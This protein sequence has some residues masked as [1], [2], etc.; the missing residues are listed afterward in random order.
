MGKKKQQQQQQQQ[1][2]GKAAAD[3]DEDALLAAAIAEAKLLKERQ[4]QDDEEK[5]IAA[6]EAT[7]KKEQALLG[8]SPHAATADA[9]MPPRQLTPNAVVEKLNEIPSFAIM[10]EKEAGAKKTFVPLRFM[11]DNGKQGP[12]TCAFFIDPAEANATLIQAKKAAPDLNL[13]VGVMPLGNAFAL[14]NGWA[15]AQ[16]SCPF[17][18]RGEPEMA[19]QVRPQLKQQLAERGLA[20]WWQFPVI[21]CDELQSPAVLPIFLTR[22][23]LNATWAACEREGPPPSKLQVI[24][25]RLLVKKLLAPFAETGFDANI[26][27]FLGSETAWNV[28]QRSLAT[29]G[30][31]AAAD[32]ASGSG[33]GTS[34]GDAAAARGIDA[35][36]KDEPPP[37]APSPPSGAAVE[38][39]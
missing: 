17:S 9:A 6:M 23:G 39:R 25:M 24:D 13:V 33:S 29:R 30:A 31:P 14:A 11:D 37:L 12:E 7:M 21:L 36:D 28:V 3:Q 19:S 16:G 34:G 20:S 35:D 1:R 27:R 18:V 8:R 26:V 38:V 32:G 4:Q 10:N 2:A 22:E 5:E 15:E